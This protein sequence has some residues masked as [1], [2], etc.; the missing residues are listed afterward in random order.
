MEE[1]STFEIMDRTPE[2]NEV[3]DI[4]YEFPEFDQLPALPE[5]YPEKIQEFS[6]LEQVLK[7]SLM[8][9]QNCFIQQMLSIEKVYKEKLENLNEFKSKLSINHHFAR[10]Y[11]IN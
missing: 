3:M 5:K 2:H 10:T 7:E 4:Q 1:E 9:F 8:A 11:H 6:E